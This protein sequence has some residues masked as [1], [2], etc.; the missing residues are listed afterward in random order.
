MQVFDDLWFL[1]AQAVAAWLYD[2][3]D[4]YPLIDTP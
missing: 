2:R 4:G 1:G 3:E